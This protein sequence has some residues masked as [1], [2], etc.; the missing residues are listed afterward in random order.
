MQEACYTARA[1]LYWLYSAKKINHLKFAPIDTNDFLTSGSLSKEYVYTKLP[2]SPASCLTQRQNVQL[3]TQV[4][5]WW[6]WCSVFRAHRHILTAISNN[7]VLTY[8][9]EPFLRSC[10]LCSHSRTSQHFKEPEGSSPCSQEPSTGPYPEPDRSS[11][12]QPILSL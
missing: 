12:Y 8:G 4:M 2:L 11:P 1:L 9:A 5:F 7:I 10:Q 6:K 3:S